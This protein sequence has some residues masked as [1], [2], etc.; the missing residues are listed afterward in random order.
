MSD[1]KPPL[2][3]HSRAEPAAGDANAS[4][5]STKNSLPPAVALAF[6]IIA[7]LGVLIVMVL[8]GNKGGSASGAPELTQLQAEANA[9]RTQLNNERVAM[10]LRPLEGGSESVE[11]IAGRL[12]KDADTMV[13][14]AASFQAMLADK[15]IEIKAKNA[16]ILRLE[17][18]RESFAAE[19]KRLN[20]ELQRALVSGS[21]ADLLRRDFDGMKAQRDALATELAS[22]REELA[23]KGKGVSADDFADLQR[24]YDETLR[25]KEFFEAKVKEL[26]GDLSKAKLFASSENELLPAAVE[27]FR[28]LR[29]LE[30]KADSE[31]ATEYSSLGVKLG[32]NVLHTL[33]FAT[34]SSV[35]TPADDELIRNLVA[36]IPDGD[37]VLAIG[38]ASETGNVDSNRVL[39][40]DRATAAA[41]LF[42]SVKRPT[43]LVQAVY[44][45]QTDRFS[46][47]IP[48]RNQIVEIWRIR[49]K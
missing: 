27:L 11:E 38:Y 47:R 37:L 41:T 4:V 15:D 26:E 8:R 13:A 29:L 31:I 39:S 42:S 49:K 46:S 24:R 28:S 23:A 3:N 9:L 48:E 33:N 14:L 17:Q 19:S 40:S 25:A 1:E 35:L 12:K 44:L 21:G 2:E 45:G 7:L 20:D 32:A 30:G 22:V 10:G 43:Q 16:E 5:S 36:D 34:G 6:V 18:L